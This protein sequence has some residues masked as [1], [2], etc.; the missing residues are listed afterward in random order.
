MIGRLVDWLLVIFGL[1]GL[2]GVTWWALYGGPNS[3]Q[4]IQDSLQIEAERAL[5]DG[6][7]DWASVV[8]DGQI[9]TISGDSP[10]YDSV[11]AAM[12]DV[13]SS[14]G[15]GG[16]VFGGILHVTETAQAAKPV[17]PYVW[18]ATRDEVGAVT[19]AGYV[20]TRAVLGELLAD[21]DA[22]AP[23]EVQNELKL[24]TG[25]PNTDWANVARQSLM[26]L[27]QLER[28]RVTLVDSKLTVRGIAP[29]D[30]TRDSVSQL[31]QQV[32][33]P[34]TSDVEILSGG[35][36]RAQVSDRSLVLTGRVSSQSERNE[37]NALANEYYPGRVIDNMTVQ[38]VEADDWM[39]SVRLV[40]P[41]FARFQS[42][43]FAFSPSDGGFRVDG[44]AT[45]SVLTYLNED[46][47]GIEEL[48]GLVLDVREAA[49]NELAWDEFD[50]APAGRSAACQMAFQSVLSNYRIVFEVGS[51]DLSRES[52]PALDQLLAV[53]RGCDGIEV[54][55]QGHTDSY[56]NRAGNIRLSEQRAAAVVNYLAGRG[57]AP[58]LFDAV[59]FGPDQPVASNDT[60][61][62]R[63]ANRRIEFRVL[64]RG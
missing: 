20:P 40:L 36:W 58:N 26:F 44:Q 57:I 47:A 7:H 64:E 13:L 62:G 28:G 4:N 8:V 61:A 23:G 51:A 24:G 33:L 5:I 45:D 56:G 59:G 18:S 1:V 17:S 16:F 15:S 35:V 27:D 34:Y 9:A 32:G 55:V 38:A 60:P 10:S 6:D 39:T 19:L 63:S 41:H 2:A 46:L 31:I 50:S 14:V 54:Q 52:G 29:D 25:E 30:D 37:I 11:E 48:W 3:A 42:G 12:A 21:A 53:A 43:E 49:P 22:I